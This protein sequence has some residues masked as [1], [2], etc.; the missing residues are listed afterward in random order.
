MDW[1]TRSTFAEPLGGLRRESAPGNSNSLTQSEAP[2]GSHSRAFLCLASE[3]AATLVPDSTR[4]HG[5]ADPRERKQAT[6]TEATMNRLGSRTRG[7]RIA[8]AGIGNVG[9]SHHPKP[10]RSLSLSPGYIRAF[11]WMSEHRRDRQSMRECES[12]SGSVSEYG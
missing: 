8:R 7:R 6:V 5:T 1:P 4:S 12:V 11:G 9:R 2:S 10:T 3:S